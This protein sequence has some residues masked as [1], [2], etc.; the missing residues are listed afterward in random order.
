MQCYLMPEY[1]GA[2]QDYYYFYKKEVD[3]WKMQKLL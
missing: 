1:N 2:E 3:E